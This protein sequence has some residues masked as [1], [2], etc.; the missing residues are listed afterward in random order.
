MKDIKEIVALNNALKSRF[1]K[2]QE[3]IAYAKTIVKKILQ[4]KLN[5]SDL[6]Q[7][8][9]TDIENELQKITK[10]LEITT[11]FETGADLAE[12]VQTTLKP[13]T[14]LPPPNA[15]EQG[16]PEP[17]PKGTGNASDPYAHYYNQ[18]SRHYEITDSDGDTISVNGR[19][20][21]INGVKRLSSEQVEK[22]GFQKGGRKSRR[23]RRT[24]F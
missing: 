6:T 12:V 17:R 5:G 24:K 11:P 23:L 7:A 21:K 8:D 2:E 1:R 16:R 9:L 20:E 4:E 19:G 3:F 10:S 18:T 22:Y 13:E 15:K 14:Q